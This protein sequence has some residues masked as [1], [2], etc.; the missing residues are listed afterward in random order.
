[1]AFQAH[2]TCVEPE[3]YVVDFSTRLYG[4]T[5]LILFALTV[6]FAAFAIITIAGGPAAIIIVLAFLT[7]WISVLL[8]YLHGRLICL[9]PTSCAIV[10]SV[11]SHKQSDPSWGKK[12]GDDD[13]TVNIL[14]A[15]G[16]LTLD[17]PIGDYLKPPQGHLVEQ[18]QKILN[19][20]RGYGDNKYQKYLHCELEGRGIRDRLDA[21]YG[22]YATLLIALAVP[23]FWIVS[24]ILGLLLIFGKGLFGEQ[25]QP[26]SGTP[27]DVGVAPGR[28]D[29]DA[30]VVIR[31]RWIYDSGHDGWNEIHPVTAMQ[32]IGHLTDTGWSGFVFKDEATKQEFKLDTVE[33]VELFQKFWC[34]MLDNADE[35]EEGGSRDD[36][37][38]DWGIH[39]GVDGCKPPPVIL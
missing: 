13:Y 12:Y 24:I 1:M 18:N 15:P 8:W 26:G 31:G 29:G 19:I 33:N 7:I 3:N 23:Y 2:T 25:G 38:N 32:V 39:P 9:G 16:P 36:P 6:G 27:L 17:A 37:K 30:V 35:A 4:F 20:N 11:Y 22:I 5:Q 34:G 10:G 21:L 14:L 28:L